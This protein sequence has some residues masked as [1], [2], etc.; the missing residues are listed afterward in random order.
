MGEIVE[1]ASGA[2]KCNNRDK[3]YMYAELTQH[4]NDS[5]N[6]MHRMLAFYMHYLYDEYDEHNIKFIALD[7][8]DRGRKRKH[9]MKIFEVTK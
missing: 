4:I 2:C 8:V 3:D 7:P 6:W 9:N 5:K 1:H